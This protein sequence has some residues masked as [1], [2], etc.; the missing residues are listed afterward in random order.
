MKQ[1]YK[2]METYDKALKLDPENYEAQEGIQ[3]VIQAT[4]SGQ[5]QDA[6]AVERAMAD[7]EIQAILNNPR[8][9]NVLSQLKDDPKQAQRSLMNDPELS[10]MIEKL[11]NAGILRQK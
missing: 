3:K 4:R 8:V 6:D 7:P 10:G 9:Q 1:Y 5:P 2:A 11:I